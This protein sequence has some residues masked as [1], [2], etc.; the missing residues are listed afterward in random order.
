MGFTLLREFSLLHLIMRQR[1]VAVGISISCMHWIKINLPV[2]MKCFSYTVRW[3]TNCNQQV[4][5][6][7]QKHHPY[8]WFLASEWHTC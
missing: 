6:F 4:C 1:K 7:S 8:V 5:V 2:K 3:Q